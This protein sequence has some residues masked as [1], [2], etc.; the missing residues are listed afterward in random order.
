MIKIAVVKGEEVIDKLS[1]VIKDSKIMQGSISLIGAVD[2][3]SI[4]TIDKYDAKKDL[5]AEYHEPLE[6]SGNGE[7]VNG[8]PHLHVTL[9]RED[10]STL[11]GHLHWGK[12]KTWFVN[13]YVTPL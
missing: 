4:S 6:L 13:V 8:T 9:G 3:C 5:L 2:A 11:F 10:K 12:V 7:I 1:K